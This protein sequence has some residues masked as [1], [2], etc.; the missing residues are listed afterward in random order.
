MTMATITTKYSIG[1]RVWLASTVLVQKSHPCPDCLDSEEWKA[2]S[3]AG[4]D[5]TFAC[6]RCSTSYMSDRDMSLRYNAHAPLVS[7]MTIGSIE[8]HTPGDLEGFNAPVKYMCVETGVGSG[9]VYNE[10]DLYETKEAAT[11]AAEAKAKER[12]QSSD[13]IPQL[14]NKTLS[15][16]D[17]QLPDAQAKAAQDAH[18]SYGYR[19]GYF[20]EDL[21]ACETIDAVKAEIEKFRQTS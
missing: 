2:T 10:G 7:E 6:P 1:D 19:V 14:Y 15:L 13:W 17:Y 5:Y 21:E 20:L 16:S 12:D 8:T 4:R 18:R 3:P 9:S 11:A